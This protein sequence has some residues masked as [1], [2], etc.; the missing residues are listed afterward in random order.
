MS[1]L[2]EKTWI[3]LGAA[4]AVICAIAVGSWR[5]SSAVAELKA[6]IRT[7]ATDR[8]TG[9]DMQEWTYQ[10]RESNAARGLAV[11]NPRQVR[12]D[13]MSAEGLK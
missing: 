7:S 4:A 13:R 12:A 3:P 5:V 6:D 1:R 8:W 2:E 11:P 9:S 10:L